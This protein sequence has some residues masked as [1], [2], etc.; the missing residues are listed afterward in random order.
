MQGTLSENEDLARTNDLTSN[1]VLISH[2][3]FDT[4]VHQEML[5]EMKH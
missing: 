2:L 1:L 4:K 5:L 3:M